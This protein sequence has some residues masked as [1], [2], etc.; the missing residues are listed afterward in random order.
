MAQT[1]KRQYGRLDLGARKLR[2]TIA[3]T[4]G[5]NGYEVTGDIAFVKDF[6]KSGVSCYIRQEA[7][8]GSGVRITIEDFKHPPL[9]GRVAWCR[10]SEDD[11][12]GSAT[13]PYRIGVEFTPADDQAREN[14]LQVWDFISKLATL[15]DTE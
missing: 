3:I 7:K 9:E 8:A 10:S 12:F 14:Q 13:H 1:E 2:A 5:A 6:S 11:P 15:V 4:D